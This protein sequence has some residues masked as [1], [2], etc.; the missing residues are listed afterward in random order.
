MY[1]WSMDFLI[2]AALWYSDHIEITDSRLHG[3]K[4]LRE[5]SEVKMKDCDIIS[6]EF[7]WSVRGIEMEDCTV[8]SEYF[9][10]RSDNLHFRNVDMKGKYSFQ[11]IENAVFENCR[12][13]TKDAFWHAKNIVVRNSVVKG[14]YLAWYSENVTFENCRI[15]GT[16]PL[17]YCRGLRL[18]DCEMTETDL[19]F[20]R[21]E[22]EAVITTP[23][24]S[25]KNPVSGHITV[26]AVGEIIRDIPEARGEIT[27]KEQK[28]K[29][30][31]A[32]A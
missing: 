21:S 6:P 23:I 13:D 31:S 4:A 25:I 12:F 30:T 9:M 5:C 29:K 1:R 14:E 27:V 2:C 28:N 17:C 19:A 7:G 8:Q 15:V 11:Y 32:C 24:L 26:P 18:I 10:M 3:I 22:V 20:E 16:Q